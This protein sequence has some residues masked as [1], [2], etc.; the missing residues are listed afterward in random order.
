MRE[1][2]RRGSGA[3][4]FYLDQA[5]YVLFLAELSSELCDVAARDTA[6]PGDDDEGRRTAPPLVL[7]GERLSGI[8]A[9]QRDDDDDADDDADNDADDDADDDDVRAEG[10]EVDEAAGGDGDGKV[11][12]GRRLAALV[13]TNGGVPIQ[14]AQV[15]QGGQ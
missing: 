4:V 12:V 6:A 11:D 5:K 2:I 3:R 14:L 7:P 10:Y 9:D 8:G 15:Q 13:R 1:A